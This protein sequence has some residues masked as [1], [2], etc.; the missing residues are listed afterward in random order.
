MSRRRSANRKFKGKHQPEKQ[1]SMTSKQP[2]MELESKDL[3][4]E[5]P[6][7]EKQAEKEGCLPLAVILEILA[8][9]YEEG[10][11]GDALCRAAVRLAEESGEIASYRARWDAAQEE[12]SGSQSIYL[13]DRR[14][15]MELIRY[16]QNKGNGEALK[17]E[18]EKLIIAEGRLLLGQSPPLKIT[19]D[20]LKKLEEFIRES[21]F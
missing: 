2:G 8:A 11:Q 5:N 3:Y 19:G 20:D 12:S 10:R 17:K 21:G 7:R 14:Q 4:Q 15:A 6:V 9:E 13:F 16:H 1:Q 18:K